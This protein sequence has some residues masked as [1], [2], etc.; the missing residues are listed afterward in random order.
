MWNIWWNMHASVIAKAID[1]QVVNTIHI[2]TKCWECCD[3]MTKSPMSMVILI[4]QSKCKPAKHEEYHQDWNKVHVL[5][6]QVC[7]QDQVGPKTHKVLLKGVRCVPRSYTT[8]ILF[9][10]L[11]V[12]WVYWCCESSGCFYP[13]KT[14]NQNRNESLNIYQNRNESFNIYA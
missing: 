7:R 8:E 13:H 5:R 9:L 2:N 3:H 6:G 11:F 4:A 12:Q 1:G 10:S 14:Y